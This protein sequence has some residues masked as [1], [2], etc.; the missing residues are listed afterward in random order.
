MKIAIAALLGLASSVAIKMDL[1]NM[2]SE[3]KNVVQTYH[4]QRLAAFDI[5]QNDLNDGDQTDTLNVIRSPFKHDY[6]AVGQSVNQKSL[7]KLMKQSSDDSS[8]SDSDEDLQA[9]SDVKLRGVEETS[10]GFAGFDAK[11]SGFV[12]NNYADGDWKD[13]YT[14][15][16]P[17]DFTSTYDMPVDTFT[18]NVIK[19]YATE[20]V[21]A[22][23][24]PNHEFF[25]LKDQA[26]M[27]AKEVVTDHLQ[28]KGEELS[29]FMKLRFEETWNHYDV[30]KEGTMDVLWAST[31]MRA[32]CKPVKDI[33]L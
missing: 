20:G 9:T 2:E 13:A 27:I 12:G 4:N 7:N 15:E 5:D 23:G 18:A 24:K 31:L 8:S 3:A 1:E 17:K 14:R 16:L 29:K 11:L 26:R 6:V 21:T 32:L 22:E 28:L 10:A 30:N 25:I 33:D 19:N